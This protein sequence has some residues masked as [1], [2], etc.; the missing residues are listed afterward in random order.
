MMDKIN[1]V[2]ANIRFIYTIQLVDII[3]ITLFIVFLW[4]IYFGT[5]LYAAFLSEH[6]AANF[7]D[8]LNSS[9]GRAFFKAMFFPL[10][11]FMIVIGVFAFPLIVV[12]KLVDKW[13][14]RH[15]N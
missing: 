4:M 6:K 8:W 14:N 7:S 13:L 3:W 15:S 1:D 11:P 2:L 10:M 5:Q 12:W 9:S